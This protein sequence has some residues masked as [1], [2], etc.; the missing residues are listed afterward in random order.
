MLSEPS[1]PSSVA[2]QSSTATTA[3]ASP[4]LAKTG[5]AAAAITDEARELKRALMTAI[6]MMNAWSQ[7]NERPF[8][9][10]E[11]MT[12]V[13]TL[14]R[15]LAFEGDS[16]DPRSDAGVHACVIALTDWTEYIPNANARKARS[17]N[18]MRI[19]VSTRTTN[20]DYRHRSLASVHV[21]VLLRHDLDKHFQQC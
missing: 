18:S 15:V 20:Y 3:P 21:L 16:W 14:K 10:R 5:P 8:T 9:P 4:G 17:H 12:V 11:F 19:C 1:C 6:L 2:V 13:S 7:S